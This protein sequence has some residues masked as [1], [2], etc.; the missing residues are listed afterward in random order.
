[1]F[2][3]PVT[4]RSVRR[5]VSPS[6]HR[7]VRRIVFGILLGAAAVIAPIAVT[8][9]AAETAGPESVAPAVH[10]AGSVT[11]P[12]SVALQR[13]VAVI[14]AS[15]ST[16]FGVDRDASFTTRL[17]DK[18][19]KPVRVTAKYGAAYHDGGIAQ[20]ASAANLSAL[21][22][23]LVVLQAGSN[24]V[25][26]SEAVVAGQVRRVVS[27]VRS[28]APGAK[29]A[30]VTVFPTVH[31]GAKAAAMDANIAAA[32]RSVDPSVTVISPLQERWLYLATK[33]GHPE[34]GAHEKLADRLAAL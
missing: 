33:D 10:A 13:P 17:G 19:G 28:E 26:A 6:L 20:L 11:R 15:I 5:S 1:M 2:A 30:L 9:A 32:A 18:T 16:G 7:M 14:G 31:R 27:Y 23:S 25:G 34:A 3:V 21:D 22:P 8:N 29:I 24:D 12:E 4:R